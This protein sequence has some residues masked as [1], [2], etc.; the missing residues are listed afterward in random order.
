MLVEMLVAM[1]LG[2]T[3]ITFVGLPACR[4]VKRRVQL[5]HLRIRLSPRDA[6]FRNPLGRV[7]V[8]PQYGHFTG[9]PRAMCFTSFLIQGHG[10][11]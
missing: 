3:S 5:R 11:I 8:L 1:F 7:S 9:L 10:A 4:A 6:V 2:F